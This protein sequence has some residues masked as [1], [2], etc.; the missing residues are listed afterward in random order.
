M[1]TVQITIIVLGALFAIC[2][3]VFFAVGK[4]ISGDNMIKIL[5]FE[6]KLTGSALVIFV[7]GVVLIIT[8]SQMNGGDDKNGGV[9]NSNN[10]APTISG[11]G[12]LNRAGAP[13]NSTGG[14]GNN[15]P[16]V[17]NS[18]PATVA[19]KSVSEQI[20]EAAA[21]L[22]RPG[23]VQSHVNA[24]ST[25]ES[26]YKQAGDEHWR[27]VE[28][29]VSFI[30]SNAQW[31]GA[32]S[33]PADRMPEDIN[34]ALQVLAARTHTW[35]NGETKKIELN[36][37]DLRGANLRFE[38]QTGANFK[39]IRLIGAHLNQAKLQYANLEEAILMDAV[40]D[41]ANLFGANLYDA[42]LQGTSIKGAD[43]QQARGACREEV[44]KY[45]TNFDARTKL[46]PCQR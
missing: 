44:L 17:V 38:G 9:T 21:L 23:D 45:T 3:I 13:V 18:S 29:L 34:K 12:N 37:L 40:L 15:T 7:L 1:N 27:I 24:I 35:K 31:K 19:G 4:G 26:L 46:S 25:L 43:L 41:D 42:D 16:A 22:S 32:E 5:G 20:N 28:L 39:G 10:D 11:N 30:R 8:A 6:F 14:N 2:G 33:R 36:G